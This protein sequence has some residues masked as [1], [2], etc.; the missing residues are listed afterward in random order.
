SSERRFGGR[1]G[2]GA[3]AIAE[4]SA[5]TKAAAAIEASRWSMEPSRA[6]SAV[7]AGRTN[8]PARLSTTRH[9]L[10][11]KGSPS[12]H[13]LRECFSPSESGRRGARGAGERAGSALLDPAQSAD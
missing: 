3:W 2:A 12:L 5:S 8:P 1:A 7:H 10:G 9:L 11:G 4:A 13:R 6:S